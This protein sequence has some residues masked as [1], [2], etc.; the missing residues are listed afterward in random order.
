M[1]ASPLQSHTPPFRQPPGVRP[2]RFDE[3]SALT[4]ERH[5][6]RKGSAGGEGGDEVEEK[7]SEV[8]NNEGGGERR[9]RGRAERGSR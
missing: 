3:F 6:S 5:G 7:E 1:V 2:W 8:E 4:V 9:W